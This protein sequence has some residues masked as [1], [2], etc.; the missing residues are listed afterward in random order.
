[1]EIREWNQGKQVGTPTGGK[2]PAVKGTYA[3]MPVCLIRYCVIPRTVFVG[4]GT[5][6][7]YVVD[8]HDPSHL[9][10]FYN[11]RRIVLIA[12]P[13]MLSWKHTKAKVMLLYSQGC[14]AMEYLRFGNN[15][16]PFN[17][18]SCSRKEKK[19]R[20]QKPAIP[21]TETRR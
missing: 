21:M 19:T 6:E 4:L 18:S 11:L 12:C 10:E 1:M 13:H 2:R 7:C 16:Q 5:Q 20:E 8:A 9:F 17:S 14:I 15:L 3:C